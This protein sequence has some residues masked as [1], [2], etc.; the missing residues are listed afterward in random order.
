MKLN[1][2]TTTYK[3]NVKKTVNE[4]ITFIKDDERENELINL[5]PEVEY[6]DSVEL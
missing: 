5:Y 1:L 6:Q 4:N 3:D 2:I